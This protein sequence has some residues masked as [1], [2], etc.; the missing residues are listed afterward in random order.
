MAGA[1]TDATQVVADTAVGE[2]SKLI[3]DLKARANAMFAEQASSLCFDTQRQLKLLDLASADPAKPQQ[4]QQL[5]AA[6][7]DMLS[8][9]ANA[10]C[11]GKFLSDRNTVCLHLD[12]D[13]EL[14][15]LADI[16][17]TSRNAS[18]LLA[19]W[20]A[21]HNNVGGRLAPLFTTYVRLANQGAADNG[22]VPPDLG[23]YWRAMFEVPNLQQMVTQLY[24]KV[25]RGGGG[26][27]EF[28]EAY[29]LGSF[30]VSVDSR[31]FLSQILPLY[32]NLHC[33]VR[34]KLSK[35]YGPSVVSRGRQFSFL[36]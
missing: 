31:P 34:R 11:C 33:Y 23:T 7:S 36:L 6:T 25:R 26:G 21:W 19:T 10:T 20:E 17:E 8:I 28:V 32:T 12:A 9:Y 5:I 30:S 24:Q 14:P 16:M 18:M 2:N 15:G 3:S 1:V 22:Y 4:N 29:S 35:F 13:G 27:G